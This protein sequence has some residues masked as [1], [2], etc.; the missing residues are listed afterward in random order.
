MFFVGKARHDLAENFSQQARNKQA[1][2]CGRNEF[3]GNIFCIV[4][5]RFVI[6]AVEIVTHTRCKRFS[7]SIDI[8]SRRICFS[9]FSAEFI[10]FCNRIRSWLPSFESR[11]YRKVYMRSKN[12]FFRLGFLDYLK[13]FSLFKNSFALHGLI[14]FLYR[15]STDIFCHYSFLIVKH[16]VVNE[17]ADNI[18]ATI[19]YV[20]S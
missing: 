2:I 5:Q 6:E 1:P 7:R 8:V 16:Q 17:I 10:Y 9:S 20:P 14:R 19:I 15:P 18:S 11:I 3:G 12:R 13:A 4:K